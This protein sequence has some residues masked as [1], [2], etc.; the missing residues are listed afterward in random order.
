M[1]TWD[2]RSGRWLDVLRNGVGKSLAVALSPD[3][4]LLTFGGYDGRAYLWNRTQAREPLPAIEH[5]GRVLGL[6]FTNDGRKFVTSS[7]DGIVRFFDAATGALELQLP[8][9]L[10][11]GIAMSFSEDSTNLWFA[12][13]DGNSVSVQQ[14]AV[15]LQ[16][17]LEHACATLVAMSLDELPAE[18]TPELRKAY[19]L[20]SEKK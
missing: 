7:A 2:V 13:S 6:T 17:L 5:R 10:G 1:R 12:G 18:N 14:I 11:N 16:P 15:G 19:A 8:T 9:H 4:S 20:C 3:S